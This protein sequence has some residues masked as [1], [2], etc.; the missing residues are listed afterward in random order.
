MGG[1]GGGEGAV[2]LKIEMCWMRKLSKV[3]GKR[4]REWGT[5][6]ITYNG[7]TTRTWKG[8]RSAETILEDNK[9]EFGGSLPTGRE[10]ISGSRRLWLLAWV[11]VQ[12]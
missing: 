12:I 4:F 9:H 3:G 6:W 8:K 10:R 2:D 11:L 7:I 5:G 1:V